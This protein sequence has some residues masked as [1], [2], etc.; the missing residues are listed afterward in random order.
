VA[1]TSRPIAVPGP[2][3]LKAVAAGAAYTCG[4]KPAGSVTCW[5]DNGS[6]EVGVYSADGGSALSGVSPILKP[7]DVVGLDSTV[8]DLATAGSNDPPNDY[9]CARMLDE[10]VQCWGGNALGLVGASDQS[11]P[12]TP[13]PGLEHVRKM[14]LG[15]S[16]GCFILDD[17]TVSCFGNVPSGEP[18]GPG[19]ELL[20][21]PNAP[22]TQTLSNMAGLSN[23]LDLAAGQ[24]HAC[25]VVQD[26][27]VECWGNW[28]WA[29]VSG[30]PVAVPGV[31]G[32]I[33]VGAGGSQTCALLSDG[34]VTCWGKGVAPRTPYRVEGVGLA[35][36][37]AVGDDY[38]CAVIRDGTVRCW[39]NDAD[40][41]LGD[42]KPVISFTYDY[43]RTPVVV[44]AAD[45]GM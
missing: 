7:T 32:A 8:L 2:I 39:G 40:G 20:F 45:G 21:S 22:G 17:G 1:A 25:A 43:Q 19:G 27:T 16:F 36:S 30:A 14:A 37:L 5:G 28:L 11:M 44:V 12:V 29:K 6:N 31:S 41:R 18:T 42:G 13:I 9:T 38:A 3:A 35:T 34:G 24:F 33:S 26:G 23:V 10:T 15:G 4:I